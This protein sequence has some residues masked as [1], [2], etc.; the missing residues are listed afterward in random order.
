MILSSII[1]DQIDLVR[2]F[3]IILS[4]YGFEATHLYTSAKVD[5]FFQKAN[6]YKLVFFDMDLKSESPLGL[7]KKSQ[8]LFPDLKSLALVNRGNVHDAVQA[9]QNGARDILE[10]PVSSIEIRKKL[11]KINILS[12]SNSI[13]IPN[14]P[15]PLNEVEKEYILKVL[16]QL[17][18]NRS[19]TATVLG[20]GR[21]TL[22]N[23]LC[24]YGL[25]E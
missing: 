5:D 16:D 3:Q 15:K 22:Y 1:S 19:K 9:M 12:K 21:K 8:E 25:Q 17:G 18:G 13:Q 14:N 7:I 6:S 20:I 24:H 4:E 23:K 11:E 2:Q 10:K